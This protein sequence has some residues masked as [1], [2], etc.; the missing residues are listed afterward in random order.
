MTVKVTT[1]VVVDIKKAPSFIQ[2]RGVMVHIVAQVVR[3]S[4]LLF[5]VTDLIRF[6]FLVKTD[7]DDMQHFRNIIR[8]I[9]HL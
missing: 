6:S 3:L 1:S 7:N 9:V 2:I 8:A 4:C 5:T